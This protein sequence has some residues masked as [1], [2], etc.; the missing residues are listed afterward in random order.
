MV[1]DEAV[2][3]TLNGQGKYFYTAKASK[4]ERPKVDGIAHST[5]KPLAL[6]R[7]L[8]RMVTPPGGTC[9]DRFA[10][11]GTTIEACLLEGMRCMAVE[12]D[13]TYL[14]LI[15]VRMRRQMPELEATG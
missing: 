11:S 15:G 13:A 6:M 3:S 1:L 5:V 14:P 10:G 9:L 2:A 12:E 7:W 4:A 8:V